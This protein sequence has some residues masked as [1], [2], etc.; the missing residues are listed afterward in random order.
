MPLASMT[1]RAGAGDDV[2][3]G[4]PAAEVA[5]RGALRKGLPVTAAAVVPAAGF[6]GV[7]SAGEL[8]LVTTVDH[9]TT[10]QYGAHL[11]GP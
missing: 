9:L 11:R 6:D 7:G 2:A 8:V 4:A 10:A 1:S 5:R 3:R